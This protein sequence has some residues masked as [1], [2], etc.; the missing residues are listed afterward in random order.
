[1]S[2]LAELMVKIG[3]DDADLEKSISS[4]GTKVGAL[5]TGIGAG[6]EG[7]ARSQQERNVT[8]EQMGRVTGE[9]SDALR[10]MATD[11][12]NVT[13]PMEDVI[14]LME[15]AT[16][17]GLRGD[18]IADYATFWDMVGDA[19][20][21]AGP[22]L[23]KAGV[24]LGQVGIAAGD[25][26]KALDAFGFITDN[27]TSSIEGF[28]GFIEKTA[29]ELGDATPDIDDM[30]G[31]L[32]ALE[33][34]G[35]SSSRAQRELRSALSAADG[36]ML[37]ALE[38][39]GISQEAYEAQV[40]AVGASSGAIEA[41]AQAYADSF[42]PMQKMQAKIEN[43]MTKYGGLA[44]AAGMVS[45]PLS[46][47]GVAMMGF[48]RLAPGFI[49][50][51]GAM[52]GAIGTKITALGAWAAATVAQGAKALA[53]MAATSVKFVAHYARMA[54]ASLVSAAKIALSWIIAMG[55]IALVIAAVVGLVALIIANWD[56]VKKWTK[57]AWEWVS[58]KIAAV[59]DW[60]KGVV[61]GG[62]TAVVGFFTNLR[63]KIKAAVTAARDWVIQKFGEL[64]T[65]A[66]GKA[67]ELVSW[68]SGL[69]GR[70]L[71]AIG[72]L[73][74]LLVDAGKNVVIG[75]WEGIKSMGGWLAEQIGGWV[76]DKIP[77]PIASVLGISSASKVTAGLGGE[78]VAGLA[79]GMSKDLRLVERSAMRLAAASIP[80]ISG[81]RTAG[82][83]TDTGD[84]MAVPAVSA[85]SG[86][87][88]NRAGS[89][90]PIYIGNVYG[91]DDFVK[92]V[93]EAGVDINRLGWQ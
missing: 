64:V 15:T 17:R 59:W 40:E 31:A 49:G 37:A 29:N 80:E 11:L 60:I 6:L 20:G 19:T 56:T 54:V 34:A 61:S 44:D 87:S 30:A 88:A 57:K 13:L 68:L 18:A 55:P 1:V 72:D 79:L 8:L 39:L 27:T 70:I 75:L 74:G 77:G 48:S 52:V 14:S 42:T 71:S 23:G 10:E 86:A 36:D 24:A 38:T 67:V 22:A 51:I 46:S 91:W 35:F 53:S 45:A 69:P 92:K 16:Q 41:N 9:G 43:L 82:V 3:V 63:D 83:S 81:V 28:L 84:Q 78:V 58:E 93:R 7:F 26:A 89:Q 4:I 25:E 85:V 73:A 2:T 76:K 66:I 65:G 50:R 12:Q 62:V 32:G 47:V 5:A 33:D 21:E 90:P